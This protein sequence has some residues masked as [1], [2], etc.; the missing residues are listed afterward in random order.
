MYFKNRKNLGLPGGL[1]VKNPPANAG[2]K[3]SVAGPERI[4]MPRDNQAIEP[5]RLTPAHSRACAVQQE[6]PLHEK[7]THHSGRVVPT[8]HK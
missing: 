1:E 3:G 8:C 2:D 6:K 5:Q 7:H 4:H